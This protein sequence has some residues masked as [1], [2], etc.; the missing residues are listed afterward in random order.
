MCKVGQPMISLNHYTPMS[1]CFLRAR[2]ESGMTKCQPSSINHCTRGRSPVGLDV[3]ITCHPS[4]Q[5]LLC[6]LLL[7]VFV[8]I[9]CPYLHCRLRIN[10]DSVPFCSR[11]WREFSDFASCATQLSLTSQPRSRAPSVPRKGQWSANNAGLA[12]GIAVALNRRDRCWHPQLLAKIMNVFA[13]DSS[14]QT[15]KARFP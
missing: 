2:A 13:A 11:K 8:L 12:M 9:R 6:V 3:P 4:I 10:T 7:L 1:C 5:V 14:V 15:V